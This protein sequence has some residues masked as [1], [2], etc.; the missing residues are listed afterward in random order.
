MEKC[1]VTV[2][3]I[4]EKFREDLKSGYSGEEINQFLYILFEEWKGWNR[5]I[6]HLNKDQVLNDGDRRRF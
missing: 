1:Q 2:N 6:T 5:G 4:L 3:D